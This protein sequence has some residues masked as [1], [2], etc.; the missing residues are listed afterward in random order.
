MIL[1]HKFYVSNE[2]SHTSRKDSMK[3]SMS[4]RGLAEKCRTY[5]H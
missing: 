2:I 5:D 1:F 4:M 3:D